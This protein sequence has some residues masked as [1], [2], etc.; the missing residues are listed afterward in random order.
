MAFCTDTDLLYWEPQV[1]RDAAAAGQTLAAGVADLAGKVVTVS[2]VSLDEA[3]VRPLDVIC[4]EGGTVSGSFPIVSVDSGAE[5]TVSVLYDGLNAADGSLD[6][7]RVGSAT[8]QPYAV[9]TFWPQR[10]VVTQLLLQAAGVDLAATDAEERVTNP[11]ALKRACVLGTLQMIYSALAASADEPAALANRAEL[12][13]RLY[14]RAMRSAR[15]E[16]DVNGDGRI[17]AR[18]LGE[19]GLVRG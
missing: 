9:R 7:S 10:R 17:V 12:Y 11:D 4:F 6:P 15:V 16:V 2:G 3:R 14:R 8:N 19:R 1:F 18:G 13:G 5:L